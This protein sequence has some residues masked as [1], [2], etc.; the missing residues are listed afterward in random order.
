[1][2]LES[3]TVLTNTIDF[4]TRP[5]LNSVSSNH[6]KIP[7]MQGANVLPTRYMN[8]RIFHLNIFVPKRKIADI[9]NAY[10]C[11]C[12]GIAFE[13][14]WLAFTPGGAGCHNFN[15]NWAGI[16]NLDKKFTTFNSLKA[17]S[18]YLRIDLLFCTPN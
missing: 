17:P 16:R 12:N 1:M 18:A 6:L 15:F 4:I 11:L 13:L 7:T 5:N 10:C 3:R 8:K 9:E 2:L 14:Y